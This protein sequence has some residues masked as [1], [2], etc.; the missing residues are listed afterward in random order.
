MGQLR[1][2]VRVLFFLCWVLI[3]F[4][5]V[6]LLWA[7]R[8]ERLRARTAQLFYRV[9]CAIVGLRFTVRGAVSSERPL[10]LIS[11]HTSY[12]DVFVLGSLVP[13]SFTPKKEV[14]SWPVIGFLCVLADC[15]FVERRPSEMQAAAAA[16][17]QRLARGKVLCIFPEGTTSDGYDVKPFKSGFLSLA[18]VLKLPVQPASMA[19]T[20]IG[21]EVI[22]PARRDEVAWVGDATFFG[23]F[24]HFLTL[25]SV[26]VEVTLHPVRHV[27]HYGDRK[28][29]TKACEVEIIQQVHAMHEAHHAR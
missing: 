10:L 7:A 11:N 12:L 5:P 22:T 19:Y 13:V 2:I 29:L 18:E 23:H 4:L 1:G 28:A 6:L 24:W 16:M 3:T 21:R 14:R 26:R 17:K 9:S 15:I 20:H 25:P 27:D 8:L